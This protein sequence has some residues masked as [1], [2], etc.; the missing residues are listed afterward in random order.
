MIRTYDSHIVNSHIWFTHLPNWGVLQKK[1][2]AVPHRVNLAPLTTAMSIT[3]RRQLCSQIVP[4]KLLGIDT[5]IIK[6]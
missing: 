5:R 1:K 6:L 2:E 4:K 3:A